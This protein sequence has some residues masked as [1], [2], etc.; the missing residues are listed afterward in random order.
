MAAQRE[1]YEKDYYKVLGVSDDGD[2][3]R[4]HQGV[5]QAGARQPSRHPPRR[6]CSRRAVQGSQRRLRRAGRRS[7]AQG[8]RRDPQARP[9]RRVPGRRARAG[10]VDSTS[11]SAATASATCSVNVRPRPTRRRPVGGRGS[12]ARRRRRGDTQPRLRRRRQGPH[13]H[14]VPHQ[15]RAVQHLPR[16]RRQARHA[17]DGVL[18]LRRPWGHRRQPGAVLVLVSV[19]GV[20]WPRCRHH[21]SMPD[22]PRQ[23]HRAPRS[24]SARRAYRPASPTA[25]RSASRAAVRPG[26]NGGPPATSSSSATSLRTGCSVETATTSPSGC[27][28][29]LPRPPS[30]AMSTCRRSMGRG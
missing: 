29:H 13:H 14:A 21:R 3:E 15:R 20:R 28:S 30:V 8:V 16:Q 12:A 7:Q 22:M 10:P 24:R 18:E 6:R 19:P 25:R 5:P 23:R 27:R 4:H 2:V 11:T 17:T 1:W 26:R 9:D